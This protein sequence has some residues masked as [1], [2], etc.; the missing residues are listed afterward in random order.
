MMPE[1]DG[2]ELAGRSKPTQRFQQRILILLPSFGKR[3]HGHQARE[4]GIAAYLQKPVRQ[5]QLYN[6]LLR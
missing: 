5:S 4:T 6:C 2:F 3:G 1:M